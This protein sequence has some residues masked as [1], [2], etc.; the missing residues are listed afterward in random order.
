[1]SK[2][3][4]RDYSCIRASLQRLNSRVRIPSREHAPEPA[5]YD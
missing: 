5:Q 4:S 1:M 2:T 3:I